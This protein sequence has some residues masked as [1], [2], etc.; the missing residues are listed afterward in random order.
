MAQAIHILVILFNPDKIVFCGSF[1]NAFPF[2]AKKSLVELKKTFKNSSG[3]YKIPK[4][5]VSDQKETIALY[6]AA[7]SVFQNLEL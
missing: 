6:G 2:F 5:T 1:A 4:L 7:Y 3:C